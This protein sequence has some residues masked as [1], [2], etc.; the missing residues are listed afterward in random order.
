MAKVLKIEPK[1]KDGLIKNLSEALEY[2]RK[3]E[4]DNLD[5]VYERSDPDNG[6]KHYHYGN[7]GAVN[8]LLDIA[9]HDILADY[10]ATCFVGFDEKE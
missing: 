3:G 9:K 1:S 2:A 8:L 10:P 7:R 5:I 6:I 4:I